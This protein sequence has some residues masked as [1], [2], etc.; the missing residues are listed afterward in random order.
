MT[1]SSL[2]VTVRRAV[3]MPWAFRGGANFTLFAQLAPT[4]RPDPP[5][6]H[7][8]V[9]LKYTGFVFELVNPMPLITSG[10]VETGALKQGE[11]ETPLGPLQIVTV[12]APLVV[13]PCWPPNDRLDGTSV[14]IGAGFTV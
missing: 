10:A 3:A 8:L 2:S 14:D 5:M 13:P 7:V 1:F 12:C 11:P 4:A 9:W 6:G